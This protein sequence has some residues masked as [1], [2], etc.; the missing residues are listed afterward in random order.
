MPR[1]EVDREFSFVGNHSPGLKIGA[2]KKKTAGFH[3]D[4]EDFAWGDGHFIV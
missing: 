4:I 3:S 2:G 1:L